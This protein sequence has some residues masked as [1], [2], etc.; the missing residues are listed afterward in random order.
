MDPD[1]QPYWMKLMQKVP[2]EDWIG[3][4]LDI[5]TA[6]EEMGQ[7]TQFISGV[8]WVSSASSSACS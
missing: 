3:Q 4:K 8:R 6:D 2:G 1:A 7:F 5:T